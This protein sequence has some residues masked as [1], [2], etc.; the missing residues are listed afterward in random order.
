MSVPILKD[1]QR[2]IVGGMPS[3]S[4]LC[5]GD[6]EMVSQLIR[7]QIIDGEWL[8]EYI[9]DG[10]SVEYD[11]L[12]MSSLANINE[13]V[14]K[15]NRFAKEREENGWTEDDWIGLSPLQSWF[16]TFEREE[17]QKRL[18]PPYRLLVFSYE[19]VDEQGNSTVPNPML[20]WTT[21]EQ[22]CRRLVNMPNLNGINVVSRY[23]LRDELEA[24]PTMP[25]VSDYV[26][27]VFNIAP[28]RYWKGKQDDRE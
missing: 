6:A 19:N 9:V 20:S 4:I 2:R 27:E 17:T 5:D 18:E 21:A 24:R 3:I 16:S 25:F 13:I 15:I 10:T 8:V 7:N 26:R 14:W 11:I 23:I 22:F 1:A 12:N 28:Y